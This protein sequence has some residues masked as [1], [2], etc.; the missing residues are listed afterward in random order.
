[1]ITAN[2]YSVADVLGDDFVHEIPPYQRPYAWTDEQA[3]QLFEDLRDAMQAGSEEPYFLGSVVLVRPQGQK[4][5]QV[6]DGQQRLTTLTIL[7]AV[8]RDAATDPQER[9]ALGSAVYIEPNPYKDQIEAVRLLAHTEDRVFFREAIQFPGAT[10]KSTPPHEP[11]TEAQQLMWANAEKLR[12]SV[13]GLGA[14]ERQAFVKFFLRKSVLVVVATESRSAALR[15]FR[16]LND[17]GLD[18]S[19]A[20]VI[21]A[22]LLGKLEGGEIAHQA[23]RWREFETDLGRLAFETLLENL[24]FV[25]EESKNR[26]TLSEAYEERFRNAS[27]S[28]VRTFLDKELAPAKK[29]ISEILDGDGEEFPVELRRKWIEALSGLRLLPNRDWLPVTLAAASRFGASE[30]LVSVTTKLEGLAWIMQLG[31]RYDT[32]RLNRY[33]DILRALRTADPELDAK[34]ASTLDENEDA[35]AALTGPLYSRFPVRVVRAI[36]ERLDRLLAEQPVLWDGQKSVEH[37]LPQNPEAGEWSQFDAAS[38]GAL[39]DTL[40]NLVLLTSRKNSSASN[41][42]FAEKKKIY[43]GQGH[44]AAGKKRATYASAQELIALTDWTPATYSERHQR[45]VSLLASHWG[46]SLPVQ[47]PTQNAAYAIAPRMIEQKTA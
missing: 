6:V 17:R 12:E 11:K 32:Q 4:V 36:L 42:P 34:L 27:A 45:H 8:L 3:L 30:R 14:Q 35:S 41:A 19:N 29:W 40:G 37:I 43:A 25:R 26:R 9:D 38:R 47:N 7:A 1:M 24:R 10:A 46:I 5:G 20:D 2:Q 16:V 33:A 28:D 39:T 31:R 13:F 18:L 15:I 23:A 22:D 21:K 44:T